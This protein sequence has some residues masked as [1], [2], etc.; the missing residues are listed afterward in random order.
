[1]ARLIGDTRDVEV[2]H[3]EAMRDLLEKPVGKRLSLPRGLIC[4][5]EYDELVIAKLP[6]ATAGGTRP[7][8]PASSC[9]FPPLRGEFP[10]QVPGETVVP[11]WRVRASIICEQSPSLPLQGVPSTRDGIHQGRSVADLDL[12]RT[13]SELLVRV[14]RRGDRFQPL[15]MSM[16]KKLQDFMVDAKIP[17]MW[18]SHIPIVCSP[19]QIIWV[20]GWRIDDRVRVTEDSR[21]IVRLEFTRGDESNR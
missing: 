10:L 7:H 9:P 17:R 16:D 13:G 21:A 12:Q 15:G 3:I 2:G 4:H 5:G 20:V 19:Q 14:R 11:G 18:R 6:P 1:V 8:D